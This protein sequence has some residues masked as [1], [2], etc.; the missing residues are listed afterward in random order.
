MSRFILGL[1]TLILLAGC[2][3]TRF[4]SSPFAATSDDALHGRWLSVGERPGELGEVELQV[5]RRYGA[6]A[7]SPEGGGFEVWDELVFIEHKK[8]GAQSGKPTD[9]NVGRDGDRRYLWVDAQWAE[10]RMGEHPRPDKGDVF[11]FRYRIEGDR[12]E[13]WR[14]N[15]RAFAHKVIDNEF[16]GEIQRSDDE[17]HVRLKSPVDPKLL[18][19]TRLWDREVLEFE[20][21]RAEPKND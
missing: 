19:N 8:E 6:H 17:L 2:E 4:E 9:L 20:R 10:E 3:T 7:D 5:A 14:A 15:T 18:R 12:L 16:K 11:L 13:V 1:T 21:A